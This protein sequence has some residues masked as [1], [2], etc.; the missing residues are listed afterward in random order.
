MKHMRKLP[1]IING[2]G[3]IVAGSSAGALKLEECKENSSLL[4][5]FNGLVFCLQLGV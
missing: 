4:H 2:K 5:S 3:C 1:S